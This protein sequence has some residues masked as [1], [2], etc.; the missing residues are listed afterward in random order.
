[1]SQTIKSVPNVGIGAKENPGTPQNVYSVRIGSRRKPRSP[2][3][4]VW[5]GRVA[6]FIS[7]GPIDL[8]FRSIQCQT[9]G[10]V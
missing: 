8:S 3:S 1:M 2:S 4:M 9:F 10:Q 5:G 6:P 7:I